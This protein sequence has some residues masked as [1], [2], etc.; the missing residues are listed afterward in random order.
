MKK[1]INNAFVRF[2]HYILNV[3]KILQK[4]EMAVLPGQIAFSM[5]LSIVPIVT[6]IGYG[7]SYFNIS[8]DTIINMLRSNFSD[9][10]VDMIVPIISG[11]SLDFNLI[12]MLCSMLYF[13][14]NG[15]S[16]IIFVSNEIYG[17]EQTDWLKRRIKAILMTF[18]LI[19]LYLFILLVP[20]FGSK[21]IDAIDYFNIKSILTSILGIMQGP[22]SWVVIFIFIKVIFTIA[23]NNSVD[24]IRIN[25]GA[26]FTSLGFIVVTNCYSYY[27][28]HFAHY[29]IFYGGLSNVMILLLWIY[30][31]SNILVIGISLTTEV[32]EEDLPK[33]GKLN[34]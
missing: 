12:I 22:I 8:M 9:S 1:K 20:V 16:S 3:I 10:I 24:P 2:K 33:S 25:F 6:L 34:F 30:F 4:P 13:A 15:P 31:L 23:P 17:F 14:S 27:V 32:N 19:L 28:N 29:D 21:I 11:N 26:I 18:L 5:I 7:A